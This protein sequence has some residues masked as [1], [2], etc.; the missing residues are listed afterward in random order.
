M[1]VGKSNAMQYMNKVL[2]NWK[3]KGVTTLEQARANS[4]PNVASA[5]NQVKKSDKYTKEQLN[6]FFSNLDEVEI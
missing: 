1:S 6:S 4:I 2:S 5:E 3:A